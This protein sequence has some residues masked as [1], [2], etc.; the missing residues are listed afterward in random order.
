MH[1]YPGERWVGHL[2]SENLY[3]DY[4]HTLP[5]H[6]QS[7]FVLKLALLQPGLKAKQ[8]GSPDSLVSQAERLLPSTQPR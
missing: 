1:L 8:G 7:P 4:R 3:A 6:S 2:G 5:E